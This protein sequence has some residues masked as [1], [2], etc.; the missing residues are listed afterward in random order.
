MLKQQND[1]PV[2]KNPVF[3]STAFYQRYKK[4]KINV[5]SIKQREI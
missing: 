4:K 2:L 1:Q 3:S 5:L